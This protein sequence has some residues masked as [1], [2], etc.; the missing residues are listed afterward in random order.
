MQS[1]V[2][3][4]VAASLQQNQVRWTGSVFVKSDDFRRLSWYTGLHLNNEGVST[5]QNL[6]EG[7]YGTVCLTES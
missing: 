5:R 3:L 7:E 6:K 4:Y 1:K 2:L